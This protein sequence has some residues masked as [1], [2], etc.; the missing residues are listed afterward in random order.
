VFGG[1][2]LKSPLLRELELMLDE[3]SKRIEALEDGIDLVIEE[4][5][6]RGQGQE[7][8]GGE[9]L[10]QFLTRLMEERVSTL[11]KERR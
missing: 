8:V 4:L 2:S 11:E 7:L 6:A 1:K 3:R 10:I 5:S 9:T